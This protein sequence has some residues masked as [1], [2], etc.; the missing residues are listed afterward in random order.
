VKVHAQK[1]SEDQLEEIY[2]IECACFSPPW[3][4]AALGGLIDSADGGILTAVDDSGAVI[5]CL[6]Y[7]D[8]YDAL[9]IANIAVLEPCRHFGVADA[10]MQAFLQISAARTFP[11]VTLEVRT[12]NKA[13]I[14]LYEK[15]GF[16]VE[17]VRK[18]YYDTRRTPTSCG[19]E[20]EGIMH[21]RNDKTNKIE[22][23]PFRRFLP[24]HFVG[25]LYTCIACV[26]YDMLFTARNTK[27]TMWIIHCDD[28][29]RI[30]G[31][32]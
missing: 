27:N 13:A 18:K 32:S 2:A 7:L 8:M 29:E 11:D 5:G 26:T 23:D 3:S 19:A 20:R 25:G 31:A 30:D 14:Q 9:H 24:V 21:Q 12:G 6:C 28:A 15:Y 1:S 10:L 22:A 16:K 17:G 4:K